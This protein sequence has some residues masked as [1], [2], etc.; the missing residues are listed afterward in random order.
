M[1]KLLSPFMILCLLAFLVVPVV[2]CAPAAD[3]GGDEATMDDTAGEMADEMD[4]AT[5]EMSDEAGEMA[6]EAGDAMEDAGDQMDDAMDDGGDSD[7]M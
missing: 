4:Q 2:A 3:E 7:S 5:D 1:K 6:D